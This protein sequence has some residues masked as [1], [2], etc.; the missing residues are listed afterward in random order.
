MDVKIENLFFGWHE[1]L[2]EKIHQTCQYIG[3]DQ[4][5]GK[6]VREADATLAKTRTSTTSSSTDLDA[7]ICGS[8]KKVYPP[9]METRITDF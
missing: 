9:F 4:G 3:I 6:E 7:G 2:P 5:T 8:S 1:K